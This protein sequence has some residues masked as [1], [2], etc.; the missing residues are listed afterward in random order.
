MRNNF[1]VPRALI[2]RGNASASLWQSTMD[3]DVILHATPGQVS[4]RVPSVFHPWLRFFINGNNLCK[5]AG[6][7]W[8]I[9]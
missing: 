6:L 1:N 7:F 4:I 8:D 5:S 2:A 9:L 3:T